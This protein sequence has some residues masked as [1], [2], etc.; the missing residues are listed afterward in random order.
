MRYDIPPQPLSTAVEA[1]AA[2]SGLQVL[3]DRPPD[4]SARSTGVKGLLTRREALERLLAGSGMKGR[5]SADGDVLLAP[6]GTAAAAPVER[7][8][9]EAPLLELDTLQV[10]AP[11]LPAHVSPPATWPLYGSVIQ[12]TVQRALRADR[13]T[14]LGDYSSVL[15]LWVTPAGRIAQV[16]PAVSSGDP[17]RDTLLSE[18]LAGLMLP[19]PPP[20]GMPQPITIRVRSSSGR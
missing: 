8:R 18:V 14:A 2:A 10:E 12:Q 15:R 11:L 5:F 16:A 19:S 4:R 13:R 20:Q 9:A 6:I 17:A 3:Y 7:P 1:Y